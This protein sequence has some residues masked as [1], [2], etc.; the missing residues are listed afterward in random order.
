MVITALSSYK[1]KLCHEQQVLRN[2]NK[3]I[4][5]KICSSSA[6]FMVPR[7]IYILNWLTW[8]SSAIQLIIIMS[9]D[10]AEVAHLIM[11]WTVNKKSAQEMNYN[12]K[13]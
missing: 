11:L 6:K 13:S 2:S 5:I 1:D 8:L 3:S 7:L 9:T 12:K 4:N 10:I